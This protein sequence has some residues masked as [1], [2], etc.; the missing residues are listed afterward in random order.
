MKKIL[1]LQLLILLTS[2]LSFSQDVGVDTLFLKNDSF[3]IGKVLKISPDMVIL[4]TKKN[5]ND[6]IVPVNQIRLLSMANGKQTTFFDG[7]NKSANGSNS[8]SFKVGFSGGY[9]FGFSSGELDCHCGY[10]F[11][12][13]KG[14]GFH[15]TATGSMPIDFFSDLY[16][17]LGYQ[18]LNLESTASATRTRA[19]YGEPAPVNV[20]ME[21]KAEIDLSSVNLDIYYK[22]KL[23][24]EFFVLGGI[25]LHIISGNELNQNE[26]IKDDNYVFYGSEKSS[27]LIYRGEIEDINS[28]QFDIRI[29][30]GYD[31]KIGEKY[32]LTPV[33][34]FDY[35][36]TKLTSSSSARIISLNFGLQLSYI[37]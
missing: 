28:F 1:I 15:I 24:S 2:Q 13:M 27:D 18:K 20:Q 9:V 22:R 33:A 11:T 30:M 26:T 32:L 23:V 17:S 37:F 8:G 3:L 5:R 21:S 29:G 19:V 7:G 36:F 4:E 31:F 14:P 25:G 10:Q 12:G 35:P 16:A 6:L 34:V